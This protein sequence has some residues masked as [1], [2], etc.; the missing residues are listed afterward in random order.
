M[1]QPI[2]GKIVK[3]NTPKPNAQDVAKWLVRD[4]QVCGVVSLCQASL[5]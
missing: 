1:G 3:Y 2:N 5:R 4:I